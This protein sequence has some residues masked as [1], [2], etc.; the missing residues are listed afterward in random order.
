MSTKCG[1]RTTRPMLMLGVRSRNGLKASDQ[2]TPSEP[3]RSAQA[4][5]FRA[6]LVLSARALSQRT[7]P[8]LRR[9]GTLEHERGTLPASPG[10]RPAAAVV[11]R[12]AFHLRA[13]KMA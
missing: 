1:A 9:R 7:T 5:N 12:V 4:D 11:R 8:P 10:L 6:R 2:A 3:A 13:E